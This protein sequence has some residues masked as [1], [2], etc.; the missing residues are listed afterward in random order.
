MGSQE[1]LRN[2]RNLIETNKNIFPFLWITLTWTWSFLGKGLLHC[3]L[4]FQSIF[5]N[6]RGGYTC[7][8]PGIP[9]LSTHI[10]SHVP[11]PALPHVDPPVSRQAQDVLSHVSCSENSCKMVLFHQIWEGTPSVF[12]PRGVSFIK[13]R[14]SQWASLR[15]VV[16]P[17]PESIPGNKTTR[18]AVSVSVGSAD[19][20]HWHSKDVL[21]IS[22]YETPCARGRACSSS[23]PAFPSL[24]FSVP[25]DQKLM[26]LL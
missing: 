7:L 19:L 21:I 24:P 8:V 25:L 5:C 20:S 18:I 22:G 4:S 17:V 12:W 13:A 3:S 10:A 26:P 16:I 2:S 1:F 14:I 6:L 11:A 23:I 15:D 9:V